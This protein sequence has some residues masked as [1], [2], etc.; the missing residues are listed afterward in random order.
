M[1]IIRE[2]RLFAGIDTLSELDHELWKR[3][4][5]IEKVGRSCTF[6]DAETLAKYAGRR[7]DPSRPQNR[8]Q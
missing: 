6:E 5:L 4:L 2:E 3:F 1:R 8:F 7:P